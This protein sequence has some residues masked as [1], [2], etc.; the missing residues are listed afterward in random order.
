MS[1][2][3]IRKILG[4]LLLGAGVLTALPAS[5]DDIAAIDPQARVGVAGWRVDGVTGEASVQRGAEPIAPLKLGQVLSPGSDIQTGAGTVVFLSRGGD[6]L[7]IQPN[8]RIRI[9]TPGTDGLL[10][11]FM[12][13]LGSVFFDVEPRRNRSFGVRAPYVAAIVKGTRFLVTVDSGN[14]SVRVDEGRVLVESGDGVSSVLVDA[15]DLAT[16]QPAYWSGIKVSS[17]GIPVAP[18]RH[19]LEL[20]VGQSAALTSGDTDGA[21]DGGA[22]DGA[23]DAVGSTVEKTTDA[24]GG[25]VTGAGKVVG[26]ALGAVGDA[27]DGVTDGVAG[28]VGGPV[29]GLVGAVGDTADAAVTGVGGVVGGVTGAVGGVVGGLGG[30][31]GGRNN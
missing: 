21:V 3:F 26:G 7:V 4:A 17:S 12:Q 1:P 15:G 6:R 2:S 27:V 29:G 11:H 18:P 24:V 20:P 16:A 22:V 28:A 14:N 23:A 30:L 5:A 8:S 25:T 31:L 9:D 19:V 10:D 13:S